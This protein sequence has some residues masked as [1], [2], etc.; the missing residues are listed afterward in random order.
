[1]FAHRLLD[2]CV[3]MQYHRAFPSDL[4]TE[5]GCSFLF[6]IQVIFLSLKLTCQ[7]QCYMVQPEVICPNILNKELSSIM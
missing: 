2:Y 5:A 7:E 1:M 3:E 6:L 4:C